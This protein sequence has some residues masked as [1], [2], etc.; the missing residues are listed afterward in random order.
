MGSP[1]AVI[2]VSISILSVIFLVTGGLFVRGNLNDIVRLLQDNNRVLHKDLRSRLQTDLSPF[3]PSLGDGEYTE[4]SR[5]TGPFHK[6]HKTYALNYHGNSDAKNQIPRSLGI[7]HLTQGVEGCESSIHNRRHT[8][9]SAGSIDDPAEANAVS[10]DLREEGQ[11]G[12][13]Q[14]MKAAKTGFGREKRGLSSGSR[15]PSWKKKGRQAENSCYNML[16]GEEQNRPSKHSIRAGKRLKGKGKGKE[17]DSSSDDVGDDEEE[18]FRP[19]RSK[20]LFSK[21]AGRHRRYYEK[22]ES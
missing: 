18:K 7:G 1:V 8:R 5:W 12:E 13:T 17:G 4:Y 2:C 3:L 11:A 20:T 16:D 10:E 21:R 6:H 14:D 19:S 15:S 9:G 22:E